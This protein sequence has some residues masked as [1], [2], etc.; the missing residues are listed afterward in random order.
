[1]EIAK[2]KVVA[3]SYTLKDPD[4]N[5]LD[6]SDKETPFNYLHGANN[7]IPGLETALEGKAQGDKMSVSID[8]QDGYGE[9]NEAL[10]RTV[11]RSLFDTEEIQAGMQFT[12]HTEQGHTL[13]TVTNVDGDD[14]TL[15]ENHPLAGVTLHFDVDVIDVREATAEELDHGHAH[16][17]EGHDH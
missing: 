2:N 15:D 8:P 6:Q 16:G 12:A 5:L 14:V 13:V 4:G 11:S 9:R 3:L 10:V 1:M 17:P 7:I